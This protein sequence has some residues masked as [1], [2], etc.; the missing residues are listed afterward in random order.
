MMAIF[1][2]LTL[3]ATI[4]T[5]IWVMFLFYASNDD[6]L[7]AAYNKV[8]DN[9]AKIEKLIMQ[10]AENKIKIEGY[11][12]LIKELLALF[13]GQ[14][15]GK[16][17]K[18]KENNS[19][20]KSGNLEGVS[21]IDIP[22]YVINRKYEFFR[23]NRV[24]K[25]LMFLTIELI[26]KKHAEN[27]VKGVIAKMLSYGLIGIALSFA[28]GAI[29]AGIVDV[30]MGLIITSI[31]IA[32]ILV[33]IYSMYD[34]VRAKAVH[35]RDQIARQFPV[36]VSK[37]ALMVSSGMI[38]PKAWQETAYSQQLELYREM[39]KT[40]EELDNLIS[41]QIA[42]ENFISRCNVKETT[43]LASAIIQNLSKGNAEIGYL[44]KDMAKE[45]WLERRH[46]AKRDS[47]KANSKLLIPTMML[48]L[49][50]ILMIMVPVAMSFSGGF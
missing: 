44:L 9:N 24:N 38:M 28:F 43:K 10:E 40:S 4:L 19:K 39:Q 34:E 20:I 36:V 42:Y 45:A 23:L 32:I 25:Q 1:I 35:R 18:L 5:G 21:I 22:G 17:D 7:I 15:Q 47:E 33:L 8:L 12:G 49:A 31:I 16:I 6:W 41:P 13:Y 26:G 11:Y 37:L 27:K 29:I 30:N 48:F 50:I 46:M 14:K 2:I 3:F